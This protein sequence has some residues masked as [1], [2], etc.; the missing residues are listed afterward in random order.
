[1]EHLMKKKKYRHKD[2]EKKWQKIWEE[3]KPYTASYDPKKPKYY[4]LDMFPYPSGAGLHVGHVTGYSATDVFTRFKRQLG[5]NV[6]HPMGWDSFGLPAEQYAI[7]TG[8]HPELTTKKNIDTY[9]RQLKSLGLS[10]DWDRELTTS[11]PDYYKWTQWIFTTLYER[12]LAYEADMMVNFCPELGTVVANE[13]MEEGKTK[14]GGYPIERVPLRQ[15]ML[16][17]T[18]YAERLIEDLELLDWPDFLKKLQLN[19]IGKSEGAKIFFKEKSTHKMIE[20]YTTRPDTLF[21]VTFVVLAPEHPLVEEITTPKQK[22]QVEAYREQAT[23][24]SD[25]QRTDL[26]FEKTGVFVGSFAINPIN[27]EKVPIWI[28]DYVL[29]HVGSGAV[30]GVPGSDER[31]FDFARLFSISIKPVVRPEEETDDLEEILTAEKCYPL[32]GVIINSK[33]EKIDLNDL[34]Y[35]EAKDKIIAFL[36]KEK[37]GSYQIRY[38]LRDWLF[39]RQRYWGEPIPIYHFE[40][41]TKRVLDLDELPLTP[42]KLTDYLPTYDAQSPLV[43]VKDWIETTDPKTG[44][45]ARRE[46]NTMPQW[47]G[48]S[49]YYL[50]F[51]DPHNEEEAW[52]KEAENY[53]MPVDLYVGGAEH[54]TLHLL[55]VR[56][57]HKVLFDCNLVKTPEPFLKFRNVGL[58]TAPSFKRLSGG[59]V[60]KEEVEEKEGGYFLKGS[61]EKLKMQIEKMSKSKLNG[62]TPDEIIEEFGADGLRLYEMFMAPFDKEKLWNTDAILGCY[63]FLH[64]FWDMAHS[65]KVTKEVSKEALKLGY[66]LVDGVLKD[67]EK[68][69]LNTAIAKMMEF[70]NAFL[71]LPSYPKRVIEWAIQTLFPFAPHISCELWEILGFKEDIHTHPYPDINP[72]Y[73]EDKEIDYVLQVNGKYRGTMKMAKGLSE[74]EL[75]DQLLHTDMAKKH[76]TKEV[77]RVIFVPNKLVN[78]VL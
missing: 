71:L 75:V 3:Q 34:F 44:K 31:D 22:S 73:L 40:D 47:A 65:E 10:Y 45:K 6:L 20:V 1:M 28:A 70:L 12:G 5:Y 58:V 18:A 39:S 74:S 32:P 62:I 68:L 16:K 66:R 36:E 37:L 49:W 41:G 69:H 21:G 14:E 2:I 55:Y 51:C 77:R 50:R 30:M 19:W 24:K 64:R 27:E 46:S 26:N 4:I 42:P 17:I 29:A 61:D 35:L 54:A 48:S 13:E 53:W 76:I 8:T 59:Y 23:K 25:L 60:S 67:L 56:F 57:W 63:R 33:N 15:W 9:R 78:F 7:K 11:D 72:A 52:S 43:K 38:K